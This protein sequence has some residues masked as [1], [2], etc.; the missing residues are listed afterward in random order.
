MNNAILDVGEKIH[1]ITRRLFVDDLRRHFAGVV[2][3][4]SEQQVRAEG[5]VFVFNAG[6]NEYLRRT[7][8]RVRVFALSVGNIINV[9]PS[10]VDI[11][12]LQYQM[13]NGRLT[14]ADG[15]RFALDINEFGA[16]S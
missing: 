7:P 9:I 11:E 2:Q 4:V 10:D 3:A 5:Y 6:T 1:F 15:R 12:G 13:V 14:I 8:K 16:T